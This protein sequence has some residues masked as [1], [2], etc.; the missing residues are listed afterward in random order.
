MVTPFRPE[1]AKALGRALPTSLYWVT[2]PPPTRQSAALANQQA[3]VKTKLA[4][5]TRGTLP[6]TPALKG[7][8]QQASSYKGWGP[9]WG[10]LCPQTYAG[11]S[12]HSVPHAVAK[13]CLT[14]LEHCLWTQPLSPQQ[15]LAALVSQR[16][17]GGWPGLAPA[18]SL[19]PASPFLGRIPPSTL[20]PHPSLSS[21]GLRQTSL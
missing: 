3:S 15:G 9:A 2:E 19:S 17:V 6:V 14:F 21:L 10:A 12:E 4:A 1:T 16:H 5:R 13:E 7:A 18:A 8:P 20:S 11:Q